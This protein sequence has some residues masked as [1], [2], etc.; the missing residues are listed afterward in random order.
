MNVIGI[1]AEY[2]PFHNGH[3]WHLEQAKRISGC[4][5]AIV[6]MSGN[7]VQRGE[8]AIF[9]KWS[10]ASAAIAAGADLVLE[11]PAL[12]VVRSAQYFATGG[13]R[14]LERLGVISH[15]SFGMES[16]DPNLPIIIEAIEDETVKQYIAERLKE[17]QPYAAAVANSIAA[18]YN[19][20]SQ[21]LSSPN[22]I[23]AIEYMRALQKYAPQIQPLPILRKGPGFHD[24]TL[25]GCFASASALRVAM[26]TYGSMNDQVKLAVPVFAQKL[27]QNLLQSGRGPV[28][29]SCL[30]NI[31]LAKLR[32]INPE[33]LT[34]LPDISEG[35]E[36]RF[37][38]SSQKSGNIEELLQLIKSKRYPKTRLQ[39]IL[40][41]L[42]LGITK[43]QTD[44]FNTKGP[45][46]ARILA[47][48]DHGRHIIKKIQHHNQVP[49]ITKVSHYLTSKQR[50][51]QS[52]TPLQEMLAIDITATDLYALSLSNPAW[53]R[54]GLD[55]LHSPVYFRP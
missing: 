48:N 17:G 34:N 37:L 8:P 53:R 15:I 6:V 11:M 35:L 22:N 36:H 43:K 54:A 27:Y 50:H 4:T 47:F 30:E 49:V 21:V 52:L 55:F 5:H 42:L 40:I 10:R 41:Q 28:D 39:R 38:A 33:L 2:N 45:L 20:D 25:Q 14:L 9:D 3:R 1:V 29:L 24:T 31:I 51:Q 12:S 26:Q 32:T 13:I 7:F 16:I 44:N 19:I 23:L 18:R 46:Y